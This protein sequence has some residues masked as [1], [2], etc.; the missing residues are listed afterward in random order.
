M[1]MYATREGSGRDNPIRVSRDLASSLAGP[2]A[3]W[4]RV[5]LHAMPDDPFE[6]EAASMDEAHRIA[7]AVA[8]RERRLRL[9]DA[10][11]QAV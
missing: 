1:T 11:I 7:V 2:K 3:G 8:R 4:W 10:T 9:T 6:I 5:T